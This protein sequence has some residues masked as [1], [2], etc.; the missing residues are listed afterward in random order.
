MGTAVEPRQGESDAGSPSLLGVVVDLASTAIPHAFVELE[1]PLN[2]CENSIRVAKD[3][4]DALSAHRLLDSGQS[5]VSAY[6]QQI[7]C[8]DCV[9]ALDLLVAVGK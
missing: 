3:T 6:D 9:V 1:A 5:H 8:H 2:E 4:D 7:S